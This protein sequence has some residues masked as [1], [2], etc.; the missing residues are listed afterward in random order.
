MVVVYWSRHTKDISDRA[1]S[2][3]V[4]LKRCISMG[5]CNRINTLGN[6]W[7]WLEARR[8]SQ[9]YSLHRYPRHQ[10]NRSGA[11]RALKGFRH[12]LHKKS[13]LYQQMYPSLITLR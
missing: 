12:P 6:R 3:K 7:V 13:L 5:N 2:Y 4:N 9:L 10:Y 11:T 8:A 1:R